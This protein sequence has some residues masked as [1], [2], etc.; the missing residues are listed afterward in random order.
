[1]R[2]CVC[3]RGPMRGVC[4][5]LGMYGMCGL[6]C[7]CVCAFVHAS[8]HGH[9]SASACGHACT[10]RPPCALEAALKP[11]TWLQAK[12]KGLSSHSLQCVLVWGS[13]LPRNRRSMAHGASNLDHGAHGKMRVGGDGFRNRGLPRAIAASSSL[14]HHAAWSC[15]TQS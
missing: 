9:R 14:L 1:V 8:E 3:V 6:L 2:V 13:L 10:E 5:C 7:V 11:R 15:P 4:V 12:P